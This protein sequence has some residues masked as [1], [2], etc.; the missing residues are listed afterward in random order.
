MKVAFGCDHG[1]YVLKDVI[2]DYL[3]KSGIDVMD[4][5]TFDDAEPVDYPDYAEKVC[6]SVTCGE[7]DFG[8]LVCGTGIGMSMYAN[9][10]KGIRC[11]L[12]SDA[13][14]AKATREHND[15]NVISMGGRILGPDL[16]VSILDIFLNTDFSGAERHKRR[17]E[18]VMAA[19][20]IED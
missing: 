13:F 4:F 16:A 5:G 3:E 1:G 2:M 6:D 17:I 18:K 9:K 11:A 19:E 14:S 20:N 12:L 15:A 8:I 10:R 7:S